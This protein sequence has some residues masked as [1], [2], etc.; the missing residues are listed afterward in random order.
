MSFIV[1]VRK[2]SL[3]LFSKKFESKYF[4]IKLS[5][6]NKCVVF[7]MLPFKIVERTI[8]SKITQYSFSLTKCYTF[9]FF[10]EHRG[11]FKNLRER[12][13]CCMTSLLL[14]ANFRAMI[15]L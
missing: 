10:E 5:K 8:N 4:F 12:L 1:D 11:R 14:F 15:H 3:N 13:G 7:S 9:S 6:I 2:L